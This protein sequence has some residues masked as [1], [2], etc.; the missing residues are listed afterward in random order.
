MHFSTLVV[1]ALATAARLILV[2]AQGPTPGGPS[3][4]TPSSLVTCEPSSFTISRGTA[5]YFIAILPGGQSA[6]APLENL[7]GLD[8]AGP[9]TWTVD[10]PAGQSETQNQALTGG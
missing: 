1:G 10:L 4:T 3:T 5:P 7:P 2:A 6:A 9:V 8:E